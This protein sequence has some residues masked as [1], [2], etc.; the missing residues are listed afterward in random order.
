M[1]EMLGVLM[2]KIATSSMNYI[3][4]IKIVCLLV[5]LMEDKQQLLIST[6]KD[7]LLTLY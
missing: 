5:V 2:Q 7:F 1:K 6:L 3:K 4:K